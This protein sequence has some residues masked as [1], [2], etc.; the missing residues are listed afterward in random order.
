MH[1]AFSH[2]FPI[3]WFLSIRQWPLWPCHRTWNHP[4]FPPA[5]HLP[6]T[7]HG[8]STACRPSF[9]VKLPMFRG[10]NMW[11]PQTGAPAVIFLMNYKPIKVWFHQSK[12]RYNVISFIMYYVSWIMDHVSCIMVY[13]VSRCIMYHGISCI[14]VY[15][16]SWYI[17]YHGIS[18][19]MVYHVSWYIMYHGIS[20][21]MVYHGISCIMYHVACSMYHV[22]CIM[23][24]HGI[25]WY[26]MVYHGISWYIMVYHGIS[27]CIMYHVSWYIMLSRKLASAS[28]SLLA[29][30]S[31][32][33]AA[34][35]H[36]VIFHVKGPPPH[37][38]P[39][40]TPPPS[41]SSSSASS[42]SSPSSS[43][44]SSSSPHP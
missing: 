25:S 11:N 20:C 1:L 9:R 31:I 18:C 37:P 15:H 22:S 19:I 44:S 42:S 8:W 35:G 2:H 43:P 16:V 3:F 34:Q 36:H 30:A 12:Y 27:W 24:Y 40:H 13:H 26:I 33:G 4:K 32:Q 28:W 21:I 7:T 10:E 5:H 6:P 14:M 38:T 23:V 39:P 17:M 29:L 41:P